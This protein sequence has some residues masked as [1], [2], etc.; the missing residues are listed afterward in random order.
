[1]NIPMPAEIIV[2][3]PETDEGRKE[4]ARRIAAAHADYVLDQIRKLDCADTQKQALLEVVMLR[5]DQ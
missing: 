5:R 3:L 1:M 2:N 4:L